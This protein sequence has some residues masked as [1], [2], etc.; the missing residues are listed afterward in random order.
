M[1]RV[2][3][4]LLFLAPLRTIYALEKRIKNRRLICA[5]FFFSGRFQLVWKKSC[6]LLFFI[7]FQN[8]PSKIPEF[9]L[10]VD[11]DYFLSFSSHIAVHD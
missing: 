8:L 5:V 2:V 9:C 6:N 1:F 7:D 4:E 11:Q 10:K 3:E